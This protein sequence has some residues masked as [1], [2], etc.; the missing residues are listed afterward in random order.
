MKF[1]A[2]FAAIVAV[3]VAVPLETSWTLQELSETLSNPHVNPAIVPYLEDALNT[4]MQALHDGHSFESISV[5]LPADVAIFEYPEVEPVIPAPVLPEAV[6]I[7][8][9]FSPLVKLI[10]NVNSQQAPAPVEVNPVDVI[11]INPVD[12][13]AVNPL[14]RN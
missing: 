11:A 9:Q 13:V 1:F 4:F 7:P 6:E 8:S 3:A 5:I 10:I 2:V 12:V 14:A